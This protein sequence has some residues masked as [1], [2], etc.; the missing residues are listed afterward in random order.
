M[1]VTTKTILRGDKARDNLREK[2]SD[3]HEVR[4]VDVQFCCKEM[5]RAFED[6]Y[7]EFSDWHEYPQYDK[8]INIY[9]VYHQ[10]KHINFCPFC[11]EKI[12]IEN[13]ETVELIRGAKRKVVDVREVTDYI[14]KP[15][16][17]E[18]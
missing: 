14:E 15:V 17:K 12:R 13:M 10:S 9:D 7:I 6:H 4:A 2:R 5:R 11:G 1:L 18:K 8:H 16:G 3:I